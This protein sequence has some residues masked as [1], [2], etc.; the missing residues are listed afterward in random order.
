M[1]KFE[2]EIPDDVWNSL[3]NNKGVKLM[4]ADLYDVTWTDGDYITE[5]LGYFDIGTYGDVIDFREDVKVK[6]LD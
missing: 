4:I 3:K 2:V 6:K 1:V 5:M